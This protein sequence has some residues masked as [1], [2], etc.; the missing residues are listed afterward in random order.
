[1]SLESIKC[2]GGVCFP[3]V[4]ENG[5][6]YYPVSWITTKVLKRSGKHG[7]LH[8]KNR[9]KYKEH[10][11][12]FT[13]EFDEGNI[14]VTK[15]ISEEGLKVLLSKTQWARLSSEQITMQNY[16]HEELGLPL[17]PTNTSKEFDTYN[18][19][20]LKE[21]D[22]YTSEIIEQQI[23]TQDKVRA[24]LCSKCLKHFPLNNTFYRIDKRRPYGYVSTCIVCEGRR[25][26]FAHYDPEK[27]QMREVSMEMYENLNNEYVIDIYKAFVNNKIKLLPNSLVNEKCF[28]KIIDYLIEENLLDKYNYR[29]KDMLTQFHLEQF[30]KIITREDLLAYFFGEDFYFY[31][32]KYPDFS[33]NK[34]KL[35][36]EIGNKILSNYIEDHNVNME[37]PLSI[38]YE[39]LLNKSR[40][41]YFTKDSLSFVVQFNKYKYPGYK[42]QMRGNNY[43][44]KDENILLDLKYLIENDMKLDINKIP[45]YLTK[46]VLKKKCSPLYHCIIN[47]NRESL[48][49]WIDRLYPNIFI[50]ADFNIN[51]YR[52][53]F[54]SDIELFV[55]EVLSKELPNVLY[56]PRNS[57]QTIRIN[58]KIPDWFAFTDHGVYVI[59][60]FGMHSE[61]Y[62]ENSRVLMYKKKME[63]KLAAYKEANGYKFLFLYPEDT[64]NDFKGIKDKVKKIN[65]DKNFTML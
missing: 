30:G 57:D 16:L 23:D 33:F 62:T 51:A 37:N 32:W 65:E 3:T 42:Y 41:R 18:L 24:R 61:K 2:V 5:I 36:Y 7:L 59:E 56:N 54:D 48:Y 55:H 13:V 15:C 28:Y 17:L 47:K 14:Q 31:P 38:N 1:M 11:K 39:S 43:Y 53:E 64:L 26:F 49:Y 22:T 9:D 21:H 45:L 19:D 29:F 20:W 8:H 44:N 52:L 6:F 40:L 58:G 12:E 34:I 25:K 46:T 35:D 4:K 50:E 60:Y 10:I 27:E 63:S